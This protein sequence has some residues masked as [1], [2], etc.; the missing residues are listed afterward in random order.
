MGHG[1]APAGGSR[2]GTSGKIEPH[3]LK[4][5]KEAGKDTVGK[6]SEGV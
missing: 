1:G 6:D 4:G 3:S 2:V 5:V